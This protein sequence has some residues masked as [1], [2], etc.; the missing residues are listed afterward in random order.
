MI[1]DADLREAEIV[2]FLVTGIKVSDRR[3]RLG[4][5]T[6]ERCDMGQQDRDKAELNRGQGLLGDKGASNF[7]MNADLSELLQRGQLDL[8][9]ANLQGSFQDGESEVAG[10]DVFGHPP[11]DDPWVKVMHNARFAFASL[12]GSEQ[13]VF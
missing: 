2:W 8:R 3:W 13:S 9:G 4:G 12:S 10:V 11:I 7:E 1:T 5:V 6:R